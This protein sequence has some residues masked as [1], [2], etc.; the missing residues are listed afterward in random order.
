VRAGCE[1]YRKSW[2]P[3]VKYNHYN[4]YLTI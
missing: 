1:V 2:E 3:V 4:L